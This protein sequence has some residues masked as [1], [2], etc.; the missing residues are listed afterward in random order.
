MIKLHDQH[1]IRLDQEAQQLF[2]NWRN[3]LDQ[4][5][6][7]LPKEIR[8]FLPKAYGNALRLAAAIDCLHQFN[9]GEAPRLILDAQGMDRGIKAAMYYLGQSVDAIRLI[10]GDEL[11]ID[12]VQAKILEALKNGPLSTT[13]INNDVFQRNVQADKIQAALQA[14][15]DSG[16]IIE[17]IEPGEDGQGRNKKVYSLAE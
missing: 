8:G 11:I 16:Q 3:E 5:K 10:L 13:E 7:R 1:T 9:K 12:P 2:I 17:K 14:L 15:I 6:A 4:Q